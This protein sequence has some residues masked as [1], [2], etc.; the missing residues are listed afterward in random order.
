MTG[1]KRRPTGGQ[2]NPE[3]LLEVLQ[4]AKTFIS[5]ADAA[6]TAAPEPASVT[7]PVDAQ[8]KKGGKKSAAKTK[9]VEK[10]EPA[11]PELKWSWEGLDDN[12]L[13]TKGYTLQF[14]ASLFE[15]VKFM[16]EHEAGLR[17]IQ[18]LSIRA[19]TE[20]VDKELPKHLTEE[21]KKALKS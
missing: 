18:K 19:I 17:S 1:L 3:Q 12:E 14:P 6:T 7:A 8:D 16:L 20:F 21:N 2:T 10:Q 11:E 9:E 4:G 5:D 13:K 15:K